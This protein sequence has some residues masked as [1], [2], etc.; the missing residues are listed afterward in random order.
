MSG[1]GHH[2]SLPLWGSSCGEELDQIGH[3]RSHGIGGYGGIHGRQNVHSIGLTK[4][5]TGRPG[6]ARNVVEAVNKKEKNESHWGQLVDDTGSSLQM[7]QQW[8]MKYVPRE[9]NKGAHVLAQL[10][11]A[12]NMDSERLDECPECIKTI[13]TAELSALVPLTWFH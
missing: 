1:S 10:A 5:P 7:L 8:E 3:A 9:V 11:T 6:D 12:S 2:H 13:I 4:D